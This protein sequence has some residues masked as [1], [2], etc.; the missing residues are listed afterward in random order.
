MNGWV[1]WLTGLSGAGKTTIARLVE[2]RLRADGWRV[3]VLD[4]DEVRTTLCRD[5]GFS[6]MDRDENVRRIGYVSRLLAEQGVIVLVAAISPYRA[7]RD[8]VRATIPNF[9]E[10]HVDCPLDVLVARDTKGL[11]R[12]AMAGELQHLTGISDPY[13]PPESPD[14]V[15]RSDGQTPADSAEVIW[16]LVC[17]RLLATTAQPA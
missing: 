14:V 13:E 3:Q 9:L 8:E 7:A 5:L 17:R 4:G 15:V 11:Y 1:V 2:P 12:R 6:R 10:V 16:R